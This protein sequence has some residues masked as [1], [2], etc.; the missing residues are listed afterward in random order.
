M[1]QRLVAV[2]FALVVTACSTTSHSRASPASAAA[3]L[4]ASSP[5]TSVSRDFVVGGDRPVTVRVPMS[6]DPVRPAP[7]LILLHG[8]G[9]S[10][11]D[12]DRY[13][14]LGDAAERRG[15]IY[16]HPDGT[17]DRAGNQFWNATDAC[18]DFYRSGVADSDYLAGVVAA[19][20]AKVAVDPKRIYFIGH[21]NGAFMSYRIACDHADLVAAIVSLAGATFVGRADCHPTAPVSVLEIHGTADDTIAFDG[22]VISGLEPGMSVAHYP[23]AEQTATA[24]ATYD[25]CDPA[26]SKSAQRVDVDADISI[27]GDPADA[28][29]ETWAGC[30]NGTVVQL[31]TIPGG[32]HAPTISNAFPDAALDFLVAHPKP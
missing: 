22:G 27:G 30:R 15:M 8:Y 17:V 3:S 24:W 29:I 19:I 4:P 25:G 2:L 31:W 32:G 6:Y 7:L 14:H 9:G 26:A 16:A 28:T 20:K 18:C 11:L 5:A 10:G 1:N 21:S 23:G 13:F 12:H